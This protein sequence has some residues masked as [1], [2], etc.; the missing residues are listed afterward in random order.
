MSSIVPKKGFLFCL[1]LGLMLL[2]S[3]NTSAQMRQ[4]Y[5][6]NVAD[7]EIYKLSF[8]SPSEGYV[9][10]RDWIGYT[11]DSGRTFTKKFITNG[12]VNFNG[13]SVNLT[14]GFGIKGVKAFNQNTVIAYGDYGL[15]PAILY[16]T[17]GGTSYTLIYH[18]QFNSLELTTGITDMIF[19]Q[20]GSIGYAIDGD[21]IL[22]TTNQGLNWATVLTRANTCFDR[23]DAIDDNNVFVISDYYTG[24]ILYPN[25]RTFNNNIILKTNNTGTSWLTVNTPGGFIKNVSFVSTSKGWLN[26]DQNLYYTSNTGASW[27]QKNNSNVSSFYAGKIKFINDSTG[28]ALKGLFEITK[29]TDSGRA[30]EPL[31]RDNNYT[32]LGH[33]HNDLQLFSAT[34]LWAG[35]GHGFLEISTNAGGTPLPRAYFLVDSAGVNTTNLV[36]LINFSRRGYTYKWFVNN[37]LVSNNYN[38][39]YTHDWQNAQDTI[40]LIVTSGSLSDTL[41]KIQIFDPPNFAVLSSF[42][43]VTGSAG[44]LIT[45]TGTNLGAVTAV[46]FGGVP[47]TSFTIVNSV[48]INAIVANG[49][50]GSVSV[51]DFHGNSARP[52]FTYFAA[53]GPSPTIT[54]ISPSSGPVGTVVTISGNNFG[55]TVANNSVF[56]GD[57]KANISS[58]SATQIVCTVPVGASFS[59]LAVLNTTTSLTARSFKPFAVTFA[60][61]SNFTSHSFEEKLRFD[62]FYPLVGYEIPYDVYGNDIDG[63]GKPDL[64]TSLSGTSDSLVIYR[65]TT[66]GNN[67]SF[68]PR[69]NVRFLSTAAS[70][71]PIGICDIDNDGK[72]DI[73]GPMKIPNTSVTAVNILRNASTPGVISFPTDAYF[74]QILGATS[75]N[76]SDI[77]NDGKTDIV[78][79]YSSQASVTT[80]HI[81]VTRNTSIPGNFSFGE[82]R[83]FQL[84]ESIVS[85]AVG[86]IDGDGKKDII[87]YTYSTSSFVL[88]N[89]SCIR[90]TST[91][92]I[93]SFAP[94]VD[95]SVPGYPQQLGTVN[96]ADYDNDG[97]LD[98]I[99]QN[100]NYYCL[101]RNIS[102]PGIIA[103]APVINTTIE[104]PGHFSQGGSVSNLNGDIKPDIL[105]GSWSFNHFT[106]FDNNS[107]PGNMITDSAVRIISSQ[108]YYTRSADFNLDGKADIITSCS[109]DHSISI[110]RNNVGAP[111]DFNICENNGTTLPADVVGTTYQW[112][113]ETASNVFTNINNNANFSGTQTSILTFTNIPITWNGYKFRCLVNNNKYSSTFRIKMKPVIVPTIHIDSVMI[114]DCH[115]TNIIF[116]ATIVNGNGIFFGTPQWYRNGNNTF[117]FGTTYSGSNFQ[118][119]DQI[120]CVYN[121]ADSC[122]N[123]TYYTS[124]IITVTGVP[125]LN[126]LSIATPTTTSCSGIPVTFTATSNNSNASSI[127]S[128]RINGVT[129]PGEILNT[130]TTTALNNGNYVYCI[131]W[132]T[133]TCGVQSNSI[134]MSITSGSVTPAVSI[135]TPTTTIC[136]GNSVTF[137][138]APVNGGNAPI[139][140]W[141]VNGLNVGTNSNTF[142][143]SVLNNNDQVKCILTS[144]ASCALPAIVSSNT[145]TISVSNTSVAP[146]VNINT[147]NT[148]I[149]LG[150]NVIFT[151][152]PVNGGP[153]PVYQWKVNGVNVGTNSSTFSTNTLTNGSIVTVV[154]TSSL[155]CA[156]PTAAVSNSIVIN[157]SSVTPSVNITTPVATI[158]PGANV[159]FTATPV[160]GGTTPFYQWKKNGINTGT[161]SNTYSS[162]TLLSGDIISVSLTS[163]ATCANPVTVNS[164]NIN[165]TVN[166]VTA[167]NISISGVTTVTIGTSTVISSVVTNGGNA[168]AYQW[169]DSTS[170]HTWQ[171]ISGATSSSVNY[172]PTS[173]GNKLKCIFTANNPCLTNNA[174]SSN[175][176]TFTVTPFFA[177][178][179]FY[180]NPVTNYLVVDGLKYRDSW[181]SV[182]VV[183]MSGAK[184][185]TVPDLTGLTRVVINME[186]LP[187]GIYICVL[188]SRFG[189]AEYYK[190][191][192]L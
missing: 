82:S 98:V 25:G 37:T 154:L 125:P 108:A 192:K 93:I 48:T 4:L 114:R 155:S 112:Q 22:K 72:F 152:I 58:A 180:P 130:F 132:F 111:V 181:E 119:G 141:Q 157:V 80:F 36:N 134:T 10:F 83:L 100:Q 185:I 44:T 1:T 33:N 75:F 144:N 186:S 67:F 53:S 105:S 102:T 42:Y 167:P 49:A 159:T 18:S 21:R 177:G 183:T 86:D 46:S 77:D 189:Y 62:Y 38:T 135:T 15:I 136:A 85:V 32:Y 13:Y 150:T 40:K 106:L 19:P 158:C 110:Y 142:T 41:T 124:N 39:T 179:T 101:Y 24:D 5:V 74:P 47:A 23:L 96:L 2:F 166:T 9:A 90:N 94:R 71:N 6:D 165:M 138:A 78:A 81:A 35:G 95:F 73:I 173:T 113:Q 182:H 50:T 92:G 17:N 187:P 103:F 164:N 31:P 68:E 76:L 91:S 143:S 88:S 131:Q 147:S 139:Y 149:C 11:T 7:N 43:P 69:L 63:D 52:G 153:A 191:V 170:T 115:G 59:P 184:V 188:S 127:Y 178:P 151:A 64:I 133:P 45:L 175:V 97:K 16:S 61:S 126:T 12:N 29:T 122:S 160:N 146:S 145:I 65:N 57:V 30:W 27:T 161:N 117:T 129:V 176:L 120:T 66:T 169:Q 28:Y 109:N 14:F 54:A 116:T 60:D 137:T 148:N 79:A 163:N 172:S 84:P 87:G 104:G 26:L 128:W 8:Y 140:Q 89:F 156:S 174:V 3:N 168:G 162:N 56:F 171:N 118:N 99:I 55:A 123:T 107:V 121:E 20:N 51:T 70:G 34:Q 190:F